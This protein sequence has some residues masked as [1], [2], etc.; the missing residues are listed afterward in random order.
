MV[1]TF[2][3]PS[4][5]AKKI[6]DRMPPDCSQQM[7][8]IAVLIQITH[9]HVDLEGKYIPPEKLTELRKECTDLIN[10]FTLEYLDGDILK[11]GISRDVG[12]ELIKRH[13]FHLGD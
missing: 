5:L 1:R 8:R 9:T 3:T 2:E 10:K 12:Q 4:D 7:A 13:R 11:F 6:V